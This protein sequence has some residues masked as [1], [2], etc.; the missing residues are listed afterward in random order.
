MSE[1]RRSSERAIASGKEPPPPAP[2]MDEE[3]EHDESEDLRVS[4]R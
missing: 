4:A 2:D 1:A 3:D